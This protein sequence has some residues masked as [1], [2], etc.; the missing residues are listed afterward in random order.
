[1]ASV[2]YENNRAIVGSWY[3]TSFHGHFRNRPRSEYSIPFRQRA[4]PSPPQKFLDQ[5][6]HRSNNHLF[7]RHDN[8]HAHA[9]EGN[10]E[11]YF[12]MGLGKRK[13]NNYQRNKNTKDLL[14]WSDRSEPL[15]STYRSQFS[16]T[17][18]PRELCNDQEPLHIRGNLGTQRR[19][20]R[21]RTTIPPRAKTAPLLAWNSTDE[22]LEFKPLVGCRSNRYADLTATQNSIYG[23]SS[24]SPNRKP[25]SNTVIQETV[26]PL[27]N[28]V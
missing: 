8:R 3:P 14:T 12:G 24:I 10:L 11:A 9:N 13:S 17:P 19:Q 7:S 23:V 5:S 22:F 20:L 15:V 2:I 26:M 21:V 1:M 25:V 16:L 28:T 4:K 18:K 6:K 27:N